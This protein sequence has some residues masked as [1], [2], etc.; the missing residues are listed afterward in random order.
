MQYTDETGNIKFK[1]KKK[2]TNKQTNN[3]AKYST[4]HQL[5]C[6]QNWLTTQF[7]KLIKM[8]SILGIAVLVKKPQFDNILDIDLFLS[9][10]NE[11]PIKRI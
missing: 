4:L 1:K 7:A 3:P 10:P 9:Q 6:E 11:L 8:Y 2:K 5:Q